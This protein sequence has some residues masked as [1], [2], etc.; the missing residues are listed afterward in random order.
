M[1]NSESDGERKPLNCT[2]LRAGA[3]ACV[4]TSTDIYSPQ[5]DSHSS[6]IPKENKDSQKRAAK[7]AAVEAD[8]GP[9]A[10]LP[11]APDSTPDLPPDVAD[12]ARRLAALP[13]AVRAS[14]LAA[15]KAAVPT[16]AAGPHE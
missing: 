12:L 7:S 14:L 5:E 4:G 16:K 6:E 1:T 2:A 11:A 13:E 8:S 3:L 15:I 9:A 10:P